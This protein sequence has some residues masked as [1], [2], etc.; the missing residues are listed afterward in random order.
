M[1]K[2]HNNKNKYVTQ[3]V[4]KVEDLERSLEFYKDIMGFKILKETEEEA[5]LSTDGVNPLVILKEPKDIRRKIEKRTG[6]YH[7]ALLLPSRS[8]LG[9]FLKNIQEKDH[10]IIGGSNH[11][12]SE[13]IYLQD[14]DDNGIEVYSDV[15]SS[16]WEWRNNKVEMTTNPLDYNDLLAEAENDTWEG[17]PK[18]TIIGHIHLHVG[19]LSKSRE[20][21]MDGLGFDL[22]Q[23]MGNSALFLSSGGYHHHIAI[24]TWNGV[25]AEPLPENSAGM[26]YYSIQFPNE[27]SRNDAID[28]LKELEYPVMKEGDHLYTKDPSENL[29]KLVI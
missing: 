18:D 4:L 7:F 22:V 11:G 20:F 23:E 1:K 28:R 15:D 10:P 25:G 8:Q 3:I 29:I 26:E 13:A 6:L 14:P 24:N 12:V 27:K 2:F 5:T 16:K 17:M 9:L 21:Y 19:D